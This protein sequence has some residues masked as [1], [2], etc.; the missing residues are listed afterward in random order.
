MEERKKR[1]EL[2]GKEERGRV[3]V[4]S[5]VR[6]IK[7][8]SD[9]QQIMDWAFGFGQPEVRPVRHQ[10]SRSPLGLTAP[11]LSSLGFDPLYM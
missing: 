11:P 6:K 3:A 4:H 8:E 7:Q 2:K 10:L 1:S 5:Q 9:S